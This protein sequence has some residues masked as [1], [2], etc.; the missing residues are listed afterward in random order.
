MKH[1]K[2]L[3]LVDLLVVI[4]TIA[5]LLGILMPALQRVRKQAKAVVCQSNLKQWAT[6]FAAYT[7]NNDGRLPKQGWYAL[8]IPVHWMYSMRQ[9]CVGTEG[10]R[11]CPMAT[12]LASAEP[13]ANQGTGGPHIRRRS[14]GAR[15]RPAYPQDQSA[16]VRGGTFMA[17]GKL[18]FQVYDE[19]TPDYYGSYGLNNWLYTP[20]EDKSFVLGGPSRSFS[21]NYWNTTNV[22]G[23]GNIPI[24]LDSWWWCSWVKDTDAPPQCDGDTS[25]FPCGCR[26]SIHRF[27]INRHQAFV[28]AAFLDNSVRTVGLKELW[29][30]KWHRRFDRAGPWTKAGGVQPDDWP[31]WMRGLNEY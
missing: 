9:F 31:S 1:E 13:S 22:N 27:C 28:N 21:A 30:L 5:L 6:I 10:I 3:T 12:K 25:H 16:D 20:D 4:A 19:W 7:N 15:S 26:N 23:A 11:C 18:R 2:G 17:W 24:F 29:T 8:G 14:V